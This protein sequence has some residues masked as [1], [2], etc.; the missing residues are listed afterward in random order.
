MKTILIVFGIIIFSMN[1][2]G[3]TATY[4]CHRTIHDEFSQ[5]TT[6]EYY[7]VRIQGKTVFLWRDFKNG[8]GDGSDLK[9][10]LNGDGSLSGTVGYGMITESKYGRTYI[11][12]KHLIS[13]NL[14]REWGDE[15]SMFITV[16]DGMATG[17]AEAG[18]L[19]RNIRQGGYNSQ[20]EYSCTYVFQK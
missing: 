5:G 4:N 15:T 7:L 2:L 14:R 12:G 1:A 13:A 20:Y 8:R 9:S 6:D 10:R 18:F 19:H 11:E 3:A 17:T 16:S